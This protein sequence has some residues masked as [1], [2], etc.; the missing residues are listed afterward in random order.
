MPQCTIGM[1]VS[2]YGWNLTLSYW[3]YC[4]VMLTF[5]VQWQLQN[6]HLL[7]LLHDFLNAWCYQCEGAM[8]TTW[9]SA[10]C[11]VFSVDWI[12]NIVRKKLWDTTFSPSVVVILLLSVLSEWAHLSFH[13]HNYLPVRESS[14]MESPTNSQNNICVIH[15]A[16]MQSSSCFSIGLPCD[17]GTAF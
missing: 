6:H 15:L 3:V 9:D 14:C 13:H 7:L 10:Q 5:H 17:R 4:R 12:M 16:G 8:R 11:K 1:N 2:E